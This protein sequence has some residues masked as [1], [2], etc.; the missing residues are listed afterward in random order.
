MPGPLVSRYGLDF[1]PF[2]SSRSFASPTLAQGEI[3][4]MTAIL[5]KILRNMNGGT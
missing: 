3:E 1:S 5:D 2:A 4:Q